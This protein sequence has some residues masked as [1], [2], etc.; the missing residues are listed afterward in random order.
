MN[1]DR[2]LTRAAGD[3][4]A[5][6]AGTIDEAREYVAR[7]K[8]NNTL[9]AYRS[10]WQDFCAWCDRHGLPALPATEEAVALYLTDL[11]KTHRASTLQRRL[12]SIAQ[13]HKA[14]GFPSPTKGRVSLVWA[15]IRRAKGTA[16]EGK[17]PALVADIRRMVATLGEDLAGRRDRAL[18]LVGFA[19]A[20]RRSELIGLDVADVAFM[21]EGLVVTL[22]RSK[23]DQ[24]GQGTKLGIPYGSR[25][26]TCPVRALRAWLEA[27][28]ITGGPVFRPVNRWGQVL[29][30]RLTGTAVA[31]IVKRCAKAA[32][33][34]PA[35]YAGHSLRAGLATSAA[36][37]G[38][39]ERIIMAQTR[40]KSLPMVRR[41]I[42]EGSLFRENA[43]AVVGL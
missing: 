11:A 43:A 8:A 30:G 23:T 22:R 2:S 25:P 16:P 5:E 26:Q 9:R 29:P 28:G 10:D 13:A 17:A 41:Y 15:G 1:E 38:A 34:D 4:P 40:H 35:R 12:S 21:D 42:R 18:L 27:A 31:L 6:L 36:Q 3:L 37:A 33:L 20:L 19:G 14:A 32:G 24:E 7:A 39:P